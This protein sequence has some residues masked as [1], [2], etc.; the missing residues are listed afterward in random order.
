V[1]A[2]G[3]CV[4]HACVVHVCMVHACMVY[5]ECVSFPGETLLRPPRGD[6]VVGPGVEVGPGVW[7]DAFAAAGYGLDEVGPWM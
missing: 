5:V 3:A 4:V 7:A 2:C 6:R 1:H